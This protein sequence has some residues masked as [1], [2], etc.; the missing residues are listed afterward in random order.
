MFGRE[1]IDVR[2][3]VSKIDAVQPSSHLSDSV[4]KGGGGN[5][6]VNLYSFQLVQ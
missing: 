2:R 5:F 4:C 1:E 3:G 6:S